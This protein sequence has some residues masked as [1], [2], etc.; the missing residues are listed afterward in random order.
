MH[1]THQLHL[2]DRARQQTWK[3]TSEVCLAH[4]STVHIMIGDMICACG[5]LHPTWHTGYPCMHP[6]CGVEVVSIEERRRCYATP[7]L[8][9]TRARPLLCMIPGIPRV[10]DL[11]PVQICPLCGD[12]RIGALEYHGTVHHRCSG[13]PATLLRM[14]CAPDTVLHYALQA[15]V[16]ECCI[17]SCYHLGPCTSHTTVRSM[18]MGDTEIHQV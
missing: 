14:L 8:I 3:C 4:E 2:Q 13:V 5:T 9:H 1:A 12:S 11:C 15:R 16:L 6:G 7:S 10:R 17:L 18:V